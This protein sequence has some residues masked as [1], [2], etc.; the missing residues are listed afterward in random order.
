NDTNPNPPPTNP[1][2]SGSFTGTCRGGFPSHRRLRHINPSFHPKGN[3]F[4]SLLW[5]GITV[6]L[7]VLLMKR[8]GEI[9]RPPRNIKLI[10]LPRIADIRRPFQTAG[11]HVHA[12]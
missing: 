2:L 11:R 5:I 12:G 6:N 1:H 9:A 3:D 7:P 10:A 4:H 8:T